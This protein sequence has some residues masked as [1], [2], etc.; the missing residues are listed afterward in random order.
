ML[1]NLSSLFL[2]AVIL[3]RTMIT[4]RPICKSACA[5]MCSYAFNCLRKVL[6]DEVV[7]TEVKRMSLAQDGYAAVFD[8]PTKVAADFTT[9][10]IADARHL[11]LYRSFYLSP[12]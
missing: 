7:R 9:G 3:L 8:L 10:E 1:S 12:S 6:P 4:D 2:C 5:Y 11:E